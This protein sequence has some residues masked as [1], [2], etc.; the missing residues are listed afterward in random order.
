MH[1]CAYAVVDNLL[2]KSNTGN[3]ERGTG[4]GQRPGIGIRGPR[5]KPPAPRGDESPARHALRRAAARGSLL[6][7]CQS[8]LSVRF[9]A[10]TAENA[11]RQASHWQGTASAQSALRPASARKSPRLLPSAT[12]T[13]HHGPRPTTDAAGRAYFGFRGCPAAQA[14]QGKDTETISI[15]SP[16]FPKAYRNPNSREN[17][18]KPAKKSTVNPATTVP[19]MA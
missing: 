14:D 1:G 12:V 2:R 3:W 11:E 17:K 16:E 8:S 6:V 15:V 5:N 7:A 19:M 10:E 9:T 18:L 13:Y 4:N